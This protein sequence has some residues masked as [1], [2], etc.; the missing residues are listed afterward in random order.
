MY[1][2]FM[3]ALYTIPPN[4]LVRESEAFACRAVCF[5]VSFTKTKKT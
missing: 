4:G 5:T 2:E 3:G 1:V